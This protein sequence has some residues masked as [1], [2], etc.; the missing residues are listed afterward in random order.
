MWLDFAGNLALNSI[1]AGIGT[2]LFVLVA[3]CVAI[4]IGYAAVYTSKR[5][6][7]WGFSIFLSYLASKYYRGNEKWGFISPKYR[8]WRHVTMPYQDP[9]IGNMELSLIERPN[10]DEYGLLKELDLDL[11]NKTWALN[12]VFKWEKESGQTVNSPYLEKL[13]E[14]FL[15]NDK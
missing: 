10:K 11:G 14:E 3:T 13:R 5:I 1:L 8:G 4:G 2:V 15:Q 7:D 12:A 6:T 9:K